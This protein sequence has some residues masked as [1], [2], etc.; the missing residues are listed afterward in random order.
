MH[1]SIIIPSLN[2]PIIDQVIDC[3]HKQTAWTA[4]SEVVVIGKDDLNL[5]PTGDNIVRLVDTGQP[6]NPARARNIGIATADHDLLVFLDS[7]CLPEKNWLAEHITAHTAGHQV[8]GGSILPDGENYWS[9]SYN[10]T[11]FHEFLTTNSPGPRDYLPTLNLSVSRE[12]VEQ[13][14][15]MDVQFT[16]GQDVEWITRMRRAGFQPYFWPEAIIRHVHSRTT[17]QSVWR[18]C[19]RSGYYM[20]QVRLDNKEMMSTPGWLKHRKGILILSPLIAAAVTGRIVKERPFILQNYWKTLPA[21]YLTKIAW[22]WGASRM[23]DPRYR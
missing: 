15:M 22:C 20:R 8:V 3:L 4:V 10:L 2:S 18:D 12:A 16:R 1:V 6:V 17:I 14:G 19:A 7:D 13:V 21:I 23:H 11:L 5:I 9:L